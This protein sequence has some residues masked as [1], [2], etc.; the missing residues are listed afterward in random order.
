[1]QSTVGQV[2]KKVIH[3]RYF[4]SF[5]SLM[6][7]SLG[8]FSSDRAFA[9]SRPTGRPNGNKM[10]TNNGQRKLGP[11]QRRQGNPHGGQRFKGQWMSGQR[12]SGGQ[13]MGGLGMGKQQMSGFGMG[14]QMR[15]GM[16]MGG[17][18]MGHMGRR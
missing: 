15:G 13:G 1:M 4:I 18:G 17:H 2:S 8:I 5:L 12:L 3:M 10:Q 11:A 14:N 6:A 9:Q 7:L 16:Q